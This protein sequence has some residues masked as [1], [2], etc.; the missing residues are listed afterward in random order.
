MDERDDSEDVVESDGEG[1]Q[2]AEGTDKH[3]RGQRETN[4]SNLGASAARALMSL[5]CRTLASLLL[6]RRCW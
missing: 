4:K 6:T 5:P 3:P 1:S 2:P